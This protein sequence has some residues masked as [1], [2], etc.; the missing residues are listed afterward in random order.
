M[1]PEAASGR[2]WLTERL[3]RGDPLVWSGYGLSLAAAEA[4]AAVVRDLGVSSYAL[5][6][7]ELARSDGENVAY[8]S[9]SAQ[10]PGRRVGL[11]VSEK[12]K[13]PLWTEAVI[14][15]RDSDHDGDPWLPLA[16]ARA[17]GHELAATLGQCAP[18]PISLPP[19]FGQQ[20]T[21][22]LVERYSP[23][24]RSVLR[25]AVDKLGPL[26][27]VVMSRQEL[28]HGMHGQLWRDP[29]RWR[30]WLGADTDDAASVVGAWCRN[31]GVEVGR[32]Q[33]ERPQPGV[34]SAIQVFD[35]ALSA[36]AIAAHNRGLST[37][38]VPLPVMVDNLRSAP[39]P[40]QRE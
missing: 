32:L 12:I 21:I 20:A 27:L 34:A 23:V 39:G 7:N 35:L 31:V 10:N 3:E 11:L 4:M 15:V 8:L 24:A 18:A 36:V 22:V 17:V 1:N 33:L 13:A 40:G 9:R 5:A 26:D 25:A 29:R 19:E 38:E 16:Y 28:G 30:V 37:D 14:S 2:R 6:P